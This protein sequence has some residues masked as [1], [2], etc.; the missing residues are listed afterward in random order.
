M[1]LEKN[2]TITLKDSTPID[3]CFCVE[4]PDAHYDDE[5]DTSYIYDEAGLSYHQIDELE[6]F[7]TSNVDA[8]L[9]DA[10]AEYE[11]AQD[12]EDELEGWDE[13]EY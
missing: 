4:K 2:Y 9:E 5:Y 1:Q 7:I 8:W 10:I 13:N 3:V 6:A 11:E 12:E